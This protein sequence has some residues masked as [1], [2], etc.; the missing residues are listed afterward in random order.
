MQ[1]LPAIDILGGKAVRLARGDYEKVTI[2]HENPVEQALIFEAQGAAWLHVVDLDGARTGKPV[3]HDLISEIIRSTALKVEVGGGIRTLDSIEKLAKLGVSRVVIGT[4]LITDPG[5]AQSAVGSFGDLIC[6]GVD[7][8]EGY[9]SIKGWREDT[10]RKANELVADLSL[11]GIRHLVY[12][13]ISRDG[14]Q[15]G[16]DTAA[17][18]GIAETAGFAV[19]ASGG[20]SSLE[21]LRRLHDLGDSV[22]E[23]AIIGRAIYEGAF[24]VSEALNALIL[25]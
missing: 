14:M 5:F 2:Y 10:T 23:G 17:Y 7:A 1:I 4:R 16:I 21:D 18:E 15:T 25:Q 11:W 24:T 12:T 19:I 3:N 22:I 8:R 9:V 20:I 13:D 6:A